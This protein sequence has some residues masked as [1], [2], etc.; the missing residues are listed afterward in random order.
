MV[1]TLIYVSLG[2]EQ[3][4]RKNHRQNH[5]HTINDLPNL[6]YSDG[7]VVRDTVRHA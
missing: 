4:G 7:F 5:L 6:Y 2:D 1:D 3:G